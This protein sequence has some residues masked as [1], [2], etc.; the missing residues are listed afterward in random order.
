ML[1][2]LRDRGV[3]IINCIQKPGFLVKPGFVLWCLYAIFRRRI[4]FFLEKRSIENLEERVITEKRLTCIYTKM[5][6]KNWL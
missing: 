6:R 4:C 5:A 3:A 1:A 2:F